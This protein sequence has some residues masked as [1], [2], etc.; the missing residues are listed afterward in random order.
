MHLGFRLWRFNPQHVL[1]IFHRLIASAISAV[2]AIPILDA[3]AFFVVGQPFA[4]IVK[5]LGDALKR[6]LGNFN[7]WRLHKLGR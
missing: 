4:G 2:D 7:P 1:G 3:G 6:G 5:L